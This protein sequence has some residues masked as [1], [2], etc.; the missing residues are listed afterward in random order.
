MNWRQQ[1][2]RALRAYPRLK[3]KEREIEQ[4]ITPV[5]GGATVQ[6]GA[7]RTTEDVALRSRITDSE[8][9]MISAVELALNMQKHYPNAAQRV[10]M[11]ELVYFRGTHTIAGAAIECNYSEDALWRWNTEILTAV[12]AA[13]HKTVRNSR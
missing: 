1:A 2:R 8:W 10:K 3:A 6:H 5:Y 7:S 9:N 12:Y 4:Q 13:M 11:V